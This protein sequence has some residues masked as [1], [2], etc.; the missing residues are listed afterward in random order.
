M[1]GLKEWPDARHNVCPEWSYWRYTK[2]EKCEFST[3]GIFCLCWSSESPGISRVERCISFAFIFWKKWHNLHF[4]N[5]DDHKSCTLLNLS[6]S[7]SVSTHLALFCF[8]FR[9][10]NNIFL[11]SLRW[12]QNAGKQ[13]QCEHTSVL[14]T[15][16]AFVCLFSCV[17]LLLYHS[18]CQRLDIAKS[19]YKTV[20][21]ES[22]IDFMYLSSSMWNDP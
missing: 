22:S 21:S 5:F 17:V 19:N 13:V 1:K 4:F 9:Q 8:V 14:L 12:W 18:V 10:I 2:V 6:R 7:S 20:S 16:S 3:T 15:S 11:K